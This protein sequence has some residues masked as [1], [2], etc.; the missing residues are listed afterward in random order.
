MPHAEHLG[1]P[2][3]HL[4]MEDEPEAYANAVAAFA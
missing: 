4:L 1:L 2:A 3:G